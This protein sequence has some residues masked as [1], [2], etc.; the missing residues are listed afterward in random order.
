[1]KN[2][3]RL[4][5]TASALLASGWSFA[6]KLELTQS[7][8]GFTIRQF[9][10]PVK[11]RF[12][13][14]DGQFAFDPKKPEAARVSITID[15][16]SARFGA[17]ET[18]NEAASTPWFN[19]AKFPQARLEASSI[20]LSGPG[21]YEVAGRLSIKGTTRSVA[22]IPVMLERSGAITYATGA[23]TIKR[24]DFKIGEGD[25]SDTSI[26]ADEIQVRFKLAMSDMAPF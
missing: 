8:V 4:V 6:Q 15:T 10:V 25:W 7:E 16:G 9:G 3:Q 24:L 1:M 18:D 13:Q 12:T 11:G 14:F 2:M 22:Q 26:V 23:F 5:L 20:K 19:T 21:K 17:P